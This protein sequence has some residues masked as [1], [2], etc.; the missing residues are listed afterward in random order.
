[1][2]ASFIPSS[3]KA[4]DDWLQINIFLITKLSELFGQLYTSF[5]DPASVVQ[6][7]TDEGIDLFGGEKVADFDTLTTPNFYVYYFVICP[8]ALPE[9]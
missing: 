7:V 4:L 8:P 2:G 5:L 1:V 9:L 3:S 6:L